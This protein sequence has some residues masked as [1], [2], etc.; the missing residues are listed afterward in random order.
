MNTKWVQGFFKPKHPEKYKGNINKIVFRSSWELKF[1]Q[2]LDQN[3]NIL[4]WSSEPFGIP[5][6]KPT[7]HKIHKYY[8]DYWIKY[9]DRNGNVIQEVVEV[10]PLAQTR[11]PKKGKGRRKKTVMY[12]QIT[13]ATNL[14]K[15]QACQAFCDKH[16]IKF[17]VVTE[18]NLFNY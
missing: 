16:N 15:W 9:R 6:Y 4:E 17:R 7:T 12:E 2:F 3:P 14:A 5:Y 1:N 8:P 10:K 13:Y 18:A 11:P